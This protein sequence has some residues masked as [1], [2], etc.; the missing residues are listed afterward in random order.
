[1]ELAD[2]R[3][4]FHMRSPLVL[5][6]CALIGVGALTLPSVMAAPVPPGPVRV[7][8]GDTL[9]I[10]ETRIRLH[11]IDAPERDQHCDGPSGAAWAC[12]QWARAHLQRLVRAGRVDCVALDTDRYGRTL[13]RCTAG[14][15]DI[16]AQMV[17]DGAA[18]AYRKYST[19][20]IG[21]EREARAAARG[22]WAG[23]PQTAPEAHRAAGRPAPGA[24]PDPACRIKG[25]IS[26]GGRIYH[27]PGQADYEA[28][29]ISTAKGEAW[30]CTEA[31]ARAAGFRPAR[32]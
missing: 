15:A 22:L 29:R 27:R 12:G 9:H 25:N 26:A 14:G 1:V 16:A 31:E 6:A 20:Y 24:A 5:V 23:G 21:Q 11:G 32:R 8:D 4:M 3:R 7:I 2:N 18:T 13:A 10:G 30:F 19:A 28:T 17:A